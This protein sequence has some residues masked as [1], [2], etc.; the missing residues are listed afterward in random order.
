MVDGEVVGSEASGSDAMSALSNT[1]GGRGELE[2]TITF[3][4]ERI[5]EEVGGSVEVGSSEECREWGRLQRDR[6]IV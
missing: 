3:R 6:R 1:G 4:K 5:I 2:N